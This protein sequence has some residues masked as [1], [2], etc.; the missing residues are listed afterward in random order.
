MEDLHIFLFSY[1]FQ[2]GGWM[3]GASSHC[4]TWLSSGFVYFL[5][6]LLSLLSFAVHFLFHFILLL[7]PWT[8]QQLWSRTSVVCRS[9]LRQLSLNKHLQ[10]WKQLTSGNLGNGVQV[11]SL[12][13]PGESSRSSSDLCRSSS[14]L[15]RPPRRHPWRFSVH[16]NTR[17]SIW[18]Y[19]D[20][21]AWVVKLCFM[22]LQIQINLNLLH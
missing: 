20:F 22:E 2:P 17:L 21:K 7:K 16:W 6:F 14:D 8:N 15:W 19:E 3:V 18:V 10:G 13:H 5:F 9:S 12:H 1:Q 11:W 4:R